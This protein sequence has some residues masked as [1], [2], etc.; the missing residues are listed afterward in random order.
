M[1][2]TNNS[3]KRGL[4]G[5]YQRHDLQEIPNSIEFMKSVGSARQERNRADQTRRESIHGGSDGDIHVANGLLC[6][7]PLLTSGFYACFRKRTS[8]SSS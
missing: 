5:G 2:M 4:T 8:M 6:T 1:M 7:V 3:V